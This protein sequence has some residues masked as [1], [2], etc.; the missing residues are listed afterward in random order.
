[1]TSRFSL[2]T[3]LRNLGKK[4]RETSSAKPAPRQ[5][6]DEKL[7][8]PGRFRAV[9]V[10][11]GEPCCVAAQAQVGVRHLARV[12]PP[13]LP[14]EACT[15]MDACYCKFLHHEDRRR[16]APRR[17]WAIVDTKI[18]NEMLLKQRGPGQVRKSRGRRKD[19]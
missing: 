7:N 6:D 8:A 14:L 15:R 2:F 17:A 12:K 10:K 13:K 11:P 1:M 5:A 18:G 16:A 3:R 4:S 9:E 19:D